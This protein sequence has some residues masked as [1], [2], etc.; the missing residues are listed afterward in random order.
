MAFVTSHGNLLTLFHIQIFLA[1]QYTIIVLLQ[2]QVSRLS[3]LKNK[4]Q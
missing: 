1:G 3:C 2:A 4:I